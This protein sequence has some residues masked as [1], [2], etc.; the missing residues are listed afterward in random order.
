MAGGFYRPSGV[1]T[2]GPLFSRE[3]LVVDLTVKDGDQQQDLTVVVNH[4]I[5]KFSP[6]GAPTDP[7]RINQAKFLNKA[8]GDMYAKDP[9]REILVVGDMND[10]PESKALKALRAEAMKNPALAAELKNLT[11]E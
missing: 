11:G 2:T 6:T 8:L 7:I 3:P 5:S 1:P 4:L 9:K 10:T